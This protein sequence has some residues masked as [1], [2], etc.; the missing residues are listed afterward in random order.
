MNI[1]EMYGVNG[2]RTGFWVQ[3]ESWGTSVAMVLMIGGQKE[4]PLRGTPPYF[5]NPSVVMDVYDCR[6]RQLISKNAD[7]SCPGTFAYRLIEKPD[8]AS[9]R[10]EI[11]ELS[12]AIVAIARHERE[13]V[14]PETILR[15]E[16]QKL[17]VWNDDDWE[18]SPAGQKLLA[19]LLNGEKVQI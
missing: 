1:Y 7:L 12:D 15:L 10:S 8:W 13:S 16:Q 18:L 2:N 6:T 4:G 14:L 17:A 3:R 5:G 19:R 9:V 11:D